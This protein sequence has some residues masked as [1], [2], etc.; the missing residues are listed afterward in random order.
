MYSL[1]LFH[2]GLPSLAW[3]A[4]LSLAT[5]Y[6]LRFGDKCSSVEPTSALSSQLTISATV[7]HALSDS[8]SS[9]STVY[10]EAILPCGIKLLML[11]VPPL[12]PVAWGVWF[13]DASSHCGFPA[14]FALPP[15]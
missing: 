11:V 12:L 3:L 2:F 9:P 4:I 1:S 10:F 8:P 15:G 13:L 6:Q 5:S 14:A 7:S